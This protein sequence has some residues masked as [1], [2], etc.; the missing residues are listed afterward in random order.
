MGLGECPNTV[1]LSLMPREKWAKDG[2][3]LLKALIKGYGI[4]F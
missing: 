2:K 3:L 1:Y 4:V